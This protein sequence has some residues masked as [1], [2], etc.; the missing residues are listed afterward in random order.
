MLA[1][2]QLTEQGTKGRAGQSGGIQYLAVINRVS[3]PAHHIQD[4]VRLLYLV[5]DAVQDGVHCTHTH[6]EVQTCS[7]DCPTQ[8]ANTRS[9][10]SCIKPCPD[11]RPRDAEGYPSANKSWDHRKPL[12]WSPTRLQRY[13]QRHI[14]GVFQ[15]EAFT[16]QSP[17]LRTRKATA[18]GIKKD[19]TIHSSLSEN[20]RRC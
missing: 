6:R 9:N 10:L 12:A 1:A 19:G 14:K 11:V 8:Q 5:V 3:S 13:Y 15:K 7:T 20:K 2:K 18:G 4:I 17:R 16:Q